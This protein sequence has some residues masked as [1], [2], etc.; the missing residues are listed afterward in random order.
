MLFYRLLFNF[1]PAY[2]GSGARV[3][4]IA[5]DWKE[6]NIRLPLSWRN[7]NYVGTLFG[8]SLY[9]AVDPMFMLMLIKILGPNYT[10]WDKA[11]SIKFIK[12]GRSTLYAHFK[13]TD[14]E[15]LEIKESLKDH[16][17][18]DRSFHVNLVDGEGKLHVAVEKTLYI[19]RKN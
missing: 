15:I 16:P 4:Y 1:F 7:R 9:T 5:K 11:A 13:I 2:R 6:I 19:S 17:S 14:Q 12:P 18:I 8:G 3:T 10:V